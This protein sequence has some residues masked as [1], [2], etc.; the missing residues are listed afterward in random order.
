MGPQARIGTPARPG[1]RG[2]AAGDRRPLGQRRR[3]DPRQTARGRSCPSAPRHPPLGCTTR[4]GGRN[5][6]TFYRD[7][8]DDMMSATDVE[9]ADALLEGTLDTTEAPSYA[10]VAEVIHALGE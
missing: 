9:L 10:G 6:M 1:G 7:V 4:R 2:A 3:V 5:A 8:P